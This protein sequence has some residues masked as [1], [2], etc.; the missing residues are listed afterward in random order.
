MVPGMRVAWL[1]IPD[2]RMYEK[3][4]TVKQAADLHTSTFTQRVV[5]AFAARPG[6]VEAHVANMIP[7]YRKRR[8]AMLE[9]LDERMP[10]GWT[11]TRP[12]GG[13]FLWVR[14]PESIDT[15]VLLERALERNVAFVPGAPFWVNRDVR[16]TLRL[17]FSNADETR[18]REGVERVAAAAATLG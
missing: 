17:N 13:L 9:A 6:A 11:W 3:V 12:E 10:P 8:D 7:V 2:A 18:I 5:H 14:A 15:T 4:V 16:N 1:V